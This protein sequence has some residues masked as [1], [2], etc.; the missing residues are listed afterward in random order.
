RRAAADQLVRGLMAGIDELREQIAAIEREQRLA[1]ARAAETQAAVAEREQQ[2]QS[3]QAAEAALRA[4]LEAA[5]GDLHAARTEVEGA[6]AQMRASHDQIEVARRELASAGAERDTLAAQLGQGREHAAGLLAELERERAERVSLEAGFAEQQ[7]AAAEAGEAVRLLEHELEQRVLLQARAQQVVADVRTQLEGLRVEAGERARRE[8][9]TEGLVNEFMATAGEALEEA[10]QRI[11][12]ARR[13]AADI[14]RQLDTE[15]EE[16]DA[17]ERE[18]RDVLAR[19]RM[20]GERRIAALSDELRAELSGGVRELERNL[21]EETGSARVAVQRPPPWL[22]AALTRMAHD[23]PETAGQLALGLLPGQSAV[24]TERLNYDVELQGAGWYRV[25]VGD[26]AAEIGSMEGPR[27]RVHAD[28]RVRTDDAG[29]AALVAHGDTS[30]LRVRATRRRGRARASLRAVPASLL[31]LHEAGARPAPSLVYLALAAGIA[32]DWTAGHE[33]AVEQELSDGGAG[34]FIVV[35]DGKPVVVTETRPAA[36]AATVRLSYS[37]LAHLLSGEPP[38][39]DDKPAI[40]GDAVAVARLNGW[41]RRA[42]GLTADAA[43]PP[44]V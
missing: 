32:S 33:F 22:P 18:L 38:A 16:R 6:H 2:L 36:V 34:C 10:E 31:E 7:A 35:H 11:E 44:A 27:P 17:M 14:Q 13:A 29:L 30:G 43:D 39:P 41:L 4:E 1:E 15:R 5:R 26:G 20:E 9:S 40:R 25:T 24:L 12:E 8:T 21:D 28:F 42:Q 37:A 3:C 23:E 19:E